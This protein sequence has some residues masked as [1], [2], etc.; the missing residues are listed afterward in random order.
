M[1]R[2]EPR[3]LRAIDRDS[4]F[5]AEFLTIARLLRARAPVSAKRCAAPVGAGSRKVRI[6][7]K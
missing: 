3:S 7:K 2:V 1:R 5:T 4:K 6:S